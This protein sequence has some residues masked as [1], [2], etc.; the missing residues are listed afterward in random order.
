MAIGIALTVA[1]N[2]HSEILVGSGNTQ[3]TSVRV[4]N[5]ND[6]VAYITR[7]RDC[8]STNSGAWD[9]KIP[10]QSYA[11]LGPGPWQTIGVYYLDQSG[12]GRQGDFVVYPSFTVSEEP[13]FVS[14]GRA[15]ATQV[16]SMDVTE[17][18]QPANPP[19]GIDRIW[20]DSNGLIHHLHS[21]GVDTILVDPLQTG[22]V[23]GNMLGAGAAAGNVGTLGGASAG[24][25]S[26]LPNIGINYV[27]AAGNNDVITGGA[28]Q[29]V[30][31]INIVP[32]TWLIFI[33][34][35]VQYNSG[36][37]N[38]YIRA[39]EQSGTELDRAYM[40]ISTIHIALQHISKLCLP[41][42][43][44]TGTT[45]NVQMH[46]LADNTL[47]VTTPYSRIIGIKLN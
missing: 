46:M 40:Q 36:D 43:N 29:N 5:P 3:Y 6:G 28:W 1:A 35:V 27:N 17:G 15:I 23:N 33:E 16:T 18:T 37:G 39:V 9:W 10:S 20:A 41:W 7:N 12:S 34:T 4:L 8:I 21:N 13:F 32:G 45:R 42:G 38:F 44:G 25:G 47:N 31:S 26:V 2:A 24:T 19:I 11:I 30:A 22:V 14:I